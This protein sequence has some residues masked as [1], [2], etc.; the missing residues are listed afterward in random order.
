MPIPA[1][2]DKTCD[3]CNRRARVARTA[4]GNSIL[5]VLCPREGRGNYQLV[6]GPVVVAHR[7]D[8]LDRAEAEENSDT[9]FYVRLSDC[10]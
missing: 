8:P 1:A 10:H 3:R 6:D 7:L 4:A 2:T 5:L 9:P